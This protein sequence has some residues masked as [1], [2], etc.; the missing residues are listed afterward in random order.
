MLVS[1]R[2]GD[3]WAPK[4]D[5]TEALRHEALH[6]VQCIEK[7]ARPLTGGDVGLRV[8]RLL[9]AAAASMRQRGQPVELVG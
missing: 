9:E 1:Y 3:M 2:S 6:F 5:A 4:L 8:V 7:S